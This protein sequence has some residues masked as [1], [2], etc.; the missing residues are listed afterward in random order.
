MKHLQNG[1]RNI[2]RLVQSIDQKLKLCMRMWMDLWK[3]LTYNMGYPVN[4]FMINR[5]Y[6]W[7]LWKNIE[8]YFD[9]SINIWNCA[10]YCQ[11]MENTSVVNGFSWFLDY[12]KNSLCQYSDGNLDTL[13]KETWKIN[14]LWIAVGDPIKNL[15]SVS[16]SS[17]CSFK[18]MYFSTNLVSITKK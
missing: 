2:K 5:S 18:T 6:I 13:F 17:S 10:F 8:I 11:S 4:H 9:R 12:E 14:G 16:F 1:C 15:N 3:L 7:I